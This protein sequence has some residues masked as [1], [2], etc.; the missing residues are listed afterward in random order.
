MYKREKKSDLYSITQQTRVSYAF[1][2]PIRTRVTD[3]VSKNPIITN[4][5][6]ITRVPA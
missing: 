1:K 4:Y 3:Y 6:L 5:S 2:L